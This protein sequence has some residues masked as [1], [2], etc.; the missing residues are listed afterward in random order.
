MK[1]RI[2]AIIIVLALCISAFCS[3]ASAAEDDRTVNGTIDGVYRSVYCYLRRIPQSVGAFMNGAGA[4]KTA[5][6]GTT[7]QMPASGTNTYSRPFSGSGT[8]Q[9][10]ATASPIASGYTITYAFAT[11]KAGAALSTLTTLSV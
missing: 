9:C 5:I 10:S 8:G 6:S 3:S 11:Y 2:I 1:K 4:S 7:T